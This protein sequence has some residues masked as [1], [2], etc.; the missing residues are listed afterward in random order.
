MMLVKNTN[1]GEWGTPIK[2]KAF[3]FIKNPKEPSLNQ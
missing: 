1:I 3:P 2:Q